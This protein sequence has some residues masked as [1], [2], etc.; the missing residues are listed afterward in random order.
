MQLQVQAE[1]VQC[2]WRQPEQLATETE[3]RR[4]NREAEKHTKVA[5]HATHVSLRPV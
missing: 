3:Q 1:C 5:Q 4:Q 2:E